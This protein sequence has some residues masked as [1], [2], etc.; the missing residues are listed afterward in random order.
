[1]D[2]RVR[3]NQE[4]MSKFHP[5]RL[6]GPYARHWRDQGRPPIIDQLGPSTYGDPPLPLGVEKL[7]ELAGQEAAITADPLGPHL[8]PKPPHPLRSPTLEY[9]PFLQGKAMMIVRKTLRKSH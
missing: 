9:I 4:Q 2:Q 8:L 6:A 3:N 7:E 1:M 5:I